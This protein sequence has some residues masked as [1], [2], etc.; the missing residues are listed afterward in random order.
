MTS[1]GTSRVESHGSGGF[2]QVTEATY[3]LIKND[4]RCEPRGK[5]N[6]KAK[7]E[8]SVWY[9]MERLVQEQLGLRAAD[10]PQPE[11]ARVAQ[12]IASVAFAGGPRGR[13][14]LRCH[15]H[16]LE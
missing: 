5:V 10:D 7:G 8:I 3:D 12:A 2:I 6:V 15:L 11:A 4:F 14:R 9:V 13:K 1:T 16:P